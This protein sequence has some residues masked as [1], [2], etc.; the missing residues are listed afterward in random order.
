MT[1]MRGRAPVWLLITI[2]AGVALT[3]CAR[4]SVVGTPVAKGMGAEVT[5]EAAEV[6][7]AGTYSRFDKVGEAEVLSSRS[8]RLDLRDLT[9]DKGAVGVAESDYATF[10]GG[11]G[12]V[13][14]QLAMDGPQG[15]LVTS[16]K[17][18]SLAGGH[19][20]QFGAV[21]FFR[22]F[23]DL[24]DAYADLLDSRWGFNTERVAYWHAQMTGPGDKSGGRTLVTGISPSGLVVEATANMSESGFV[25]IKYVVLL[26]DEYYTPDTIANLID[27]GSTSP[28]VAPPSHDW[29]AQS[30][31]RT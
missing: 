20:D 25:L 23:S 18:L 14:L 8:V 31:R 27:Y 2:L 11:A 30:R 3:G 16:T 29:P 10:L 7:G 9:I 21:H 12:S 5:E 28:R 24:E 19:D 26:S 22:E 6:Q 13:D 1:G 15:R 4:S 17:T